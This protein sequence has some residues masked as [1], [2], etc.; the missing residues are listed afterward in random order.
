MAKTLKNF[1]YS[2]K[3]HKNHGHRKTVRSVLIRGGRGHKTMSHYK[4]GKKMYTVKHPLTVV[5]IVTI[6]QGKFIPEL[7]RD[8]KKH[9]K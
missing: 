7:F 5:E 4:K 6:R 3:E 8:M 1:H 2:N 9:K